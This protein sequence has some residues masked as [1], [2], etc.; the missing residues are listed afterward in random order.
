MKITDEELAAW[1]DFEPAGQFK[2]T[3]SF[4]RF[5]GMLKHA[6]ISGIRAAS[7]RAEGSSALGWRD[8]ESAPKSG[9]IIGAWQDGR[10][11][12]FA[13]VFNECGEWVD[14]F[15]DHIHQPT[16]WQPLPEPPAKP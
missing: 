14:V 7:T 15:S 13:Q 2:E 3:M 8:I 9:Y 4:A 1:C 6:F 16:H 11:W 10:R 12:R 5:N